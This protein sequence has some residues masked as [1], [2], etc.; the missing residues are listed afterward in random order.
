MPIF[1]LFNDNLAICLRF[2][3]EDS[4][5]VRHRFN[6]HGI[7]FPFLQIK[8][9]V[10]EEAG[11]NAFCTSVTRSSQ[12]AR[13]FP[14]C[15]EGKVRGKCTGERYK[16]NARRDMHIHAYMYIPPCILSFLLAWLQGASVAIATAL[17]SEEEK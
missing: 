2:S 12:V 15:H 5:N 7:I 1:P 9:Q 4:E 14:V 10:G 11:K 13:V 3:F 8:T 17:S 16:R 6:P